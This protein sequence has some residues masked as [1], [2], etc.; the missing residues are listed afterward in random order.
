MHFPGHRRAAF[1]RCRWPRTASFTTP[2]RTAACS[3]ST[4]P[5]A[6]CCGPYFPELDDQLVAP[7]PLAVQPRHGH[8]RRQALLGTVDGRLIALDAKTGKPAWDTKLIDS[9]ADRRLHRRTAVRAR[10]RD[11]RRAGR[12]MAVSRP[13]LR[14]RR[15]DRQE[16]VGILHLGG[17]PEAMKT[18]GNDTWRIGGGGGWMPGTYDRRPTRYGGASPIPIRCTTGPAPTG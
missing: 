2:A 14:R 9:Q 5:P 7:D 3:R 1:S 11:H 17:T 10:H 12:R 4:A 16:E 15:G 13:D 8:G 18:W 6:R